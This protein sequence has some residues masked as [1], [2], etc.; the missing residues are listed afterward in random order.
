MSEWR[1]MTQLYSFS[2]KHQE[3]K[4]MTV[5]KDTDSLICFLN[6]VLKSIKEYRSAN[7]IMMV[8]QYSL[9]LSCTSILF[10]K[11]IS[12]QQLIYHSY[13]MSFISSCQHSLSR[14]IIKYHIYQ[15]FFDCS[16]YLD[17]IVDA[18]NCNIQL[19]LKIMTQAQMHLKTE[20]FV[21]CERKAE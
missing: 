3:E 2:L 17:Y 10:F 20:L 14:N 7:Y 8:G 13:S 12:N 4:T 21:L 9:C 15:S 1:D 11:N 19:M 16:S 5:L 6:S 18:A